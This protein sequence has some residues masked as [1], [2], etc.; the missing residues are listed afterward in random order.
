MQLHHNSKY[1]TCAIIHNYLSSY[2]PFTCIKSILDYGYDYKKRG[3]N[4]NAFL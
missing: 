2:E 3:I 4:K 1:K